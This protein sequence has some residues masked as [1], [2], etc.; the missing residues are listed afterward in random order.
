M[1]KTKFLIKIIIFSFIFIFHQISFSISSIDADITFNHGYRIDRLN[2][3][4]A[5]NGVNI[6]SELKWN[7]LQIYETE[8]KTSL[9]IDNGIYLRLAIG[10]GWILAGENQDS[11]YDGSNRSA[12]YSRSNN[13]ADKGYVFDVSIGGGYQFE[14]IIKKL[15]LTPLFGFAYYSQYLRMTDGSQTIASSGRTP[16]LGTFDGLNSSYNAHWFSLWLGFDSVY[17]AGVFTF[18]LGF[19]AHAVY[20]Y[21]EAN[22][23]LR[24]DLKHPLSYIHYAPGIG[25][26]SFL[27]ISISI[28]ENCFL[29]LDY[30]FRYYHTFAGSDKTFMADGGIYT[31]RLNE[32]N[33]WSNKI[34][35]G[36]SYQ[37]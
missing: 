14:L 36:I 5:G 16:D 17:K 24:D 6:L 26:D 34:M 12:E 25:I 37:L 1:N 20:Y 31:T 9:L 4:I 2:W 18:L 30:H 15:Y 35:L 23:N 7:N 28:A 27:R 13:Q 21:A 19:E 3:N 8:L 32:V 11:D 22:W 29:N 33:W 10:F